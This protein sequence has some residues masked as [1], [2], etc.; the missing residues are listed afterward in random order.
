MGSA[1]ARARRPRR[2]RRRPP[3]APSSTRRS[4]G[5]RPPWAAAASAPRSALRL[6]RCSPARATPGCRSPPPSARRPP[7]PRR[8]ARR[9]VS[10]RC[11]R[12]P[13]SRRSAASRPSAACRPP[14]PSARRQVPGGLGTG[15]FGG[16][17][18]SSP[19]VAPSAR[20]RAG[21]T[22]A[23]RRRRPVRAAASGPSAAATSHRRSSRAASAASVGR[24]SEPAPAVAGARRRHVL[25]RRPGPRTDA[26]ALGLPGAVGGLRRL[27]LGDG[28]GR[29]DRRGGVSGGGARAAAAAREGGASLELV[30]GVDGIDNSRSL[31]L[32]VASSYFTLPSAAAAWSRFT[33]LRFGPLPRLP[34]FGW[35]ALFKFPACCNATADGFSMG[36]VSTAPPPAG[37]LLQRFAASAQQILVEAEDEERRAG[38]GHRGV[39]RLARDAKVGELRD[40]V[41]A[42]RR[43][44]QR[45]RNARS[46]GLCF[47]CPPLVI[48]PASLNV[49]R[50]SSARPGPP[51]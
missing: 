21:L 23:A 40:E 30:C 16:G 37:A 7:P 4:R 47:E 24:G 34:R 32:R 19:G 27:G 14:R 20:P 10:R 48:S 29:A 26:V 13:A 49:G 28:V 22:P 35:P 43:D 15:A 50:V 42:A 9:P 41:P 25:R 5:S 33:H 18:A 12:R 36:W 8:R 17:F 38:V 2:R 44:A 45:R 11:R 39:A 1:A 3:A 46:S 31:A 51:K 6:S